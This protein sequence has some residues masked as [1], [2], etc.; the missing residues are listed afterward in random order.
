MQLLET[1]HGFLEPVES[2]EPEASRRKPWRCRWH[3]E[4]DGKM[5]RK[6]HGAMDA[7]IWGQVT[8][9]RAQKSADRRADRKAAESA[10]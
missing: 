3:R 8:E 5:P 1:A 7:A 6:V 2:V 10:N 9:W 4:T